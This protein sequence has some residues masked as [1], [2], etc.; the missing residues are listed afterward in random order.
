MLFWREFVREG[1]LVGF[2]QGGNTVW[3]LSR[4][5]LWNFYLEENTSWVLS[6]IAVDM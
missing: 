2:S 5:E 4:R 1:T 3:E 6:G